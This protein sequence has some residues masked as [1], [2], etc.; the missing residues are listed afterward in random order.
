MEILVPIVCI[1][2]TVVIAFAFLL[3]R[4]LIFKLI[5]QP[6]KEK[7][8]AFA[9]HFEE[10]LLKPDFA[11]LEKHFGHALPQQLKS[12]Y[13]NQVEIL[14]KDFEVV[15]NDTG[16]GKHVWY[17]SFYQPADLENL[18]DAWPAAKEVF[19]F[20]NDGWGNGYTVDPR[21]DDPP[22][23]FYDHEDGGWSRVA[24]GFSEFMAMQRREME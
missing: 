18:R 19:E 13:Q 7:I 24:N 4:D 11:G 9:K 6:S 23:M 21:L 8:A 10:R 20:A 16:T 12:L 3:C 1:L 22:V 14:K 5:F 17:I 2:T 15:G